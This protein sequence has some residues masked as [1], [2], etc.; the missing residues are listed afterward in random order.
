MKHIK[1]FEEVG[2]T[3]NTPLELKYTLSDKEL[4]NRG[5]TFQKL[6]AAN[7]ITHR[8]DIPDETGYTVWCW[9][10]GKNIEVEDWYDSTGNILKFFKDNYDEWK[11]FNDKLPRPSEYMKLRKHKKTHDIISIDLKEYYSSM[12]SNTKQDEYLEKYKDYSKITLYVEDT[13]KLIEEIEIL[14]GKKL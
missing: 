9:S 11:E 2:I 5:Y 6:Y 13:F 10:K 3:K 8:K 4:K 7:Y 12:V 1:T 14:M